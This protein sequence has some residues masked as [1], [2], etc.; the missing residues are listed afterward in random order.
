M[1]KEE[2]RMLIGVPVEIGK[3]KEKLGKLQ[4]FLADA[5]RKNITSETVKVW[6]KELRDAMYEATDI[7]D[8][9]H[10][11][12]MERGP[13]RD[14]GCL[15][16]L[17]FCMRGPLHAHKIGKS[18]KDLNLKLDNIENSKEPH[19]FAAVLQNYPDRQRNVEPYD[20]TKRETSC[21][22][23]PLSVVGEKIEKDT[24]GLVEKLIA[25]DE[26]S[27]HEHNII[28][29][30][31]VG[32]GGIGKSTL[33]RKI[34]ND[35][36][37]QQ[38]FTKRIW[39][40]VNQKPNNTTL[41]K[42][43]IAEG[44]EH[45]KIDGPSAKNLLENELKK[46]L[47]GQKLLIVMDDVWNHQEAWD[48]VLKI[49]LA[50]AN[51]AA[52]SRVL[53]TTRH[54]EVSQGMNVK[55]PFRVDKLDPEDAWSLLKKE[56]GGKNGEH[57]F[58]DLKAIGMK[59][60]EKCDGL[61][62]ALKVMGGLLHH[63]KATPGDWGEVLNESMWSVSKNTSELNYAV[64]LS[65]DDLSPSL[66]QCFL[67]YSL[68]PDKG[69]NLY[70]QDVVG[71]WIA[72]GF[73]PSDP[74]KELEV[75]RKNYDDLISRNLIDPDPEYNTH[76]V[77]RMH[78]V[79]RSFGQHLARNDALSI[80]AGE[81]S[82]LTRLSAP[83]QFL[84]LCLCSEGSEQNVEWSSLLTQRS[85]RTFFSIG[86]IKFSTGHSLAPFS[87]LRTLCLYSLGC[88]AL[89]HS[90]CELKHLRLLIMV[91]CNITELPKNIG[92]LKLLQFISIRKN[93]SEMMKLPKSIVQLPKLRTLTLARTKIDIIPKGFR[94][95]ENLRMLGGFPVNVD[96]EWCSLQEL[97]SLNQLNTLAITDLDRVPISSLAKEAMLG[98]KEHLC[99]LGLT[100]SDST[101]LREDGMLEIRDHVVTEQEKRLIQEVFDDLC[102]PPSL[103]D[104]TIHRYFGCQLPKWMTST[105]ATPLKYLRILIITDLHFCTDLPDGLSGLLYLEDMEIDRAP[106]IKR[107]GH[108]FLQPDDN[109]DSHSSSMRL[110]FPKLQKLKLKGLVEWKEWVW[111]KQVRAMA[112]LETLH[113]DRFKLS[114]IPPGLAAHAGALRELSVHN[115]ALLSTIENLAS[116]VRLEVYFNPNL[117]RIGNMPKLQTLLVSNCAKMKVLEGVDALQRL[118]LTDYDMVTLPRFLRGVNPRQLQLECLSSLLTYIAAEKCSPEWVKFSHIQ[119]V[120]AYAN[121]EGIPR[122]WC[123]LYTRK[124]YNFSP[125]ISPYASRQVEEIRRAYRN[126]GLLHI[127]LL[128]T[129]TGAMLILLVL[130]G[131]W[132][133]LRQQI[134]GHKE[135]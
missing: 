73:I 50:N 69:I 8:L 128:L 38:K 43:A 83:D 120:K 89:V 77:C 33:A 125:Y 119:Q 65:Y 15:K 104:L 48:D 71:L 39:L 124:P 64:C 116:L 94:R 84:R 34:F 61:P 112:K 129:V 6:V 132:H 13:S 72:E 53:V 86:P 14:L 11:K 98:A 49:P 109:H 23:D 100:C 78:D 41:L 24:R 117:E 21:G 133:Q 97:G 51:L 32:V 80:H 127:C 54:D 87:R 3:M 103:K 90:L 92:M 110:P 67:Y 12:A 105:A 63:K 25:K 134:H 47:Q 130:S 99:S 7:L 59:I 27:H 131:W 35:E 108:E 102:P 5:D 30:A 42:N 75:G 114:L 95:L 31:I 76:R 68:L 9:C 56:A 121:G 122:K 28:A 58:E 93:K 79:I 2:V 57:D 52:G 62:L 17:L 135:Q 4:V 74:E 37:I 44:G 60:A 46:V 91:E 19:K 66:K 115:A 16:P 101:K 123:V 10:L 106:A 18:I 55:E 81:T 22:F 70:E 40:S 88:D 1:A 26:T 111:E 20:P 36:I 107:V 29:L 118:E 85:V 96:G 113:L 82:S 126:R 45:I